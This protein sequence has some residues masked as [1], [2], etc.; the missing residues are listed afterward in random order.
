MVLA[1]VGEFS[2]VELP[3]L[4]RSILDG[5]LPPAALLDTLTRSVLVDLPAPESFPAREAQQLLVHLAFCGASVARHYQYPD[6][7]HRTTPER[8]FE[9]LWV[10]ADRIP[11]R[12]Y[13]T[14]LAAQTRTG[15]CARDSYA[16]LV[17]WNVPT[18]EVWWTGE[19]MAV[20]PGVFDDRSVR[21]YTG[22]R[23]ERLFFELVKKSETLERA[24]NDLLEPLSSGVVGLLSAEAMRRTL[25]AVALLGVLRQLNSDFGRLPAGAGLRP[26]HFVDVF[27]QFAPHWE[28]GD[29]PPS[30]AQDPEALKRDLLLGLD[31]PDRD[32][33][34]ERQFP[35]LLDVERR[36][37]I[38]L[39]GRPPL[40]RMLLA[41]L[42]F[43][44]ATLGAMSGLELRRAVRR[45]PTLAAWYLL[46]TAHARA[47]G[48]HLA[49]AK[50]FLFRVA[51]AR[52]AAGIPDTGLVSRLRGTTGMDE[53]L[54][55]RLVRARHNHALSGLHQIP[56]LELLALAGIDPP[57]PAVHVDVDAVV[58]F[59][60][61]GGGEA[62][63]SPG[64]RHRDLVASAPR[65]RHLPGRP[66]QSTGEPWRG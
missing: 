62:G 55:D 38:R 41:S 22:D 18:S 46:L 24:V 15:H 54:L 45:H 60:R 11:F 61:T 40:P 43:D 8:A 56:H 65:T 19:R 29:I 20:L 49:L 17:R 52:E 3:Q 14:R 27:R 10:G 34:I 64:P 37:V 66:A 5:E 31:I 26:E 51:R 59:T 9:P 16:S 1:R 57:E 23:G 35:A 30:G 21:T 53:S 63:P 4:N 44:E 12:T 36:E 47:S 32:W 13:F 2:L 58:G 50:K 7:S 33:H 48:A 6:V 42:R 25:V 39:M 28:A